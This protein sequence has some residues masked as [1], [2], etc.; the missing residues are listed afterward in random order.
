M[1]VDR[2]NIGELKKLNYVIHDK[3]F[4][5]DEIIFDEDKN[6][7]RL[8]FGDNKNCRDECLKVKGVSNYNI[9]D[10]EKVGIYD[11]YA[12]SIDLQKS[13]IYIDGCIPI[14]I[15]LDVMQDFEISILE[16][17]RKI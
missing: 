6:E 11:I 12:L 5:V 3:W 16:K 2:N 17:N 8:F 4:S 13:Q 9:I 1:L 15:V 7:F 14:N 10:T